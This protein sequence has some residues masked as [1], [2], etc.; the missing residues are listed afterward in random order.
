MHTVVRYDKTP[1]LTL[2]SFDSMEVIIMKQSRFS[3]DFLL[4][5]LG[6]IVSLFGNAVIR[7]ALPLHLLNQT[8][9][10]ALYGAVTA[11]AF[12]P[13]VLLTPVGGLLCDRV[14]KR[15][16]MAALDFS[17]A[18]LLLAFIHLTGRVPAVPLLSVTLMLLYGIAGAYQPTVQASVPALVPPER[19]EAANSII[20]AISSLASL[21]GPVLGGMLYGVWGLPPILILSTACFALS[22]L[23][24]LFIH[25]PHV[26]QP[27]SAGLFDV[28][29]SDFSLS[30]RFLRRQKPVLLRTTLMVCGINLFLSSMINVGMPCLITQTF[31]FSP[32][33]A[34]ELYG[35]AQG[36]LG[37]GGLAG[38]MCAGLLA[39][40]MTLQG[41]GR[42]LVACTACAF[43]IGAALLIAPSPMIRYGVLTAC[44]FLIFVFSTI[45]SVQVI[46]FIQRE[47]PRELTGKVMSVSLTLSMCAQPLGSALYGVL[48]EICG[49]LEYAV[50]LF[51]VLIS[52]AIALRAKRI[53]SPLPPSSLQP[54]VLQNSEPW[55][56]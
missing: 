15:S 42:L 17:T 48:F 26:P 14:N 46:S 55:K 11:C 52:L 2:I 21:L 16:V 8:G 44:G 47:T 12:V 20:N 29:R 27:A 1:S 4:V 7:F 23:M 5:V 19:L 22:A 41:S 33:R 49:G 28:I 56:G 39:G 31:G 25:I 10:S 6:Q 18:L 40:R 38:G 30:F 35:A 32:A 43:P 24:E 3:R 53:L 13:A 54:A 51:S 36:V 45:F 50:V 37:I 9:S 34:S